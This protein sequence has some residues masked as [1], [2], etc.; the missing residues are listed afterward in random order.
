MSFA[1]NW[2]LSNN[3]HSAVDLLL[4]TAN[5]EQAR[6]FALRLDMDFALPFPKE[7]VKYQA[8]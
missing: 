5:T 7:V 6:S 2:L 1:K 8:S 4:L 3:S